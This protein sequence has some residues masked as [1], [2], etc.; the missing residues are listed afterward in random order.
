MKKINRKFL[1]EV[2]NLKI[3]KKSDLNINNVNIN[4]T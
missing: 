3:V 4:I 2:A 1:N